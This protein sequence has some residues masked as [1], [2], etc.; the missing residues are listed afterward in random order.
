MQTRTS[1]LG[2]RISRAL[3]LPFC[4]ILTAVTCHAQT[5][6]STYGDRYPRPDRPREVK[7][8]SF[9]VG[10]GLL[11]VPEHRAVLKAVW[12]DL[13]AT[14]S[15]SEDGEIERG[16]SGEKL[17][18]RPDIH[19]AFLRWIHH[20]PVTRTVPGEERCEVCP[21]SGVIIVY[22]GRQRLDF[23]R[24][25]CR[26]CEGTGKRKVDLVYTITCP[27]DRLPPK[28]KTPR[29]L[30]QEHLEVSAAAG[31]PAAR[32]KLATV[33]RTGTRIVPPNRSKSLEL[34]QG[35]AE[36][37][38]L[39]G[40]RGLAE[41]LSEKAVR[42]SDRAFAILV[43]RLW[44]TLGRSRYLA[45]DQPDETP[46]DALAMTMLMDQA[47]ELYVANKRGFLV[48]GV[49]ALVR[50]IDLGAQS[51]LR[52]AVASHLKSNNAEFSA[53]SLRALV[54][55]AGGLNREAFAILG[56]I[57]EKGLAGP[58]NPHAAHVLYSIASLLGTEESMR[59]HV[60][61]VAGQASPRLTQELLQTFAQFRRLGNCPITFVE[62]VLNLKPD[63]Q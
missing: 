58:P 28:S 17:V 44:A 3:L 30:A 53:D 60:A 55:L 2:A 37:G 32:L 18:D 7:Q 21:G 59:A 63:T 36:E 49:P 40:L 12:D 62:S 8:L 48:E 13:A 25:P 24:F 16:G 54:S 19:E 15:Y 9:E 41:L 46:L 23:K 22:E 5:R 1:T 43:G 38:N 57:S 31:D 29:Q 39:D 27:F 61:R 6:S 52:L 50:A 20:N 4:A 51:P 35:L 42:P 26:A 47:V 45:I 10:Q 11:I 33:Y 56:S 14:H 34:Y